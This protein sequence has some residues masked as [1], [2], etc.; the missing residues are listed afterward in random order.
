[1][2]TLKAIASGL[3]GAGALNVINETA[4]RFIPD[5]PRLDLEGEQ[6][7]SRRIRDLGV[8][9]PRGNA[10]Y[11]SAMAF[12]VALNTLYYAA[13][14]A[15]DPKRAPLTGA[16]LGFAGGVANVLVAPALGLSPHTM[17]RTPAMTAM[18]IA[19]YTAGGFAAGAMYRLLSRR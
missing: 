14:A 19:W 1:M 15:G 10:L 2:D 8:T 12:D 13:V 6:F 18:T 4:R 3:A 16:A 7:V 5:A 11:G 17:R 9:P